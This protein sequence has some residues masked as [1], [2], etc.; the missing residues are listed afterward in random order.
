MN[1]GDGTIDNE[2]WG[3]RRFLYFNNGGSAATS[4]P[5]EAIDHYNYL[6]GFWLDNSPLCYGGTGHTSGGG[7]PSVP[8][9][10]MFPGKPTTDPCGWGQGGTPMPDWSEETEENPPGDRRFVQSAGPFI[11]VPGA[12]NDITVGAVYAK[13]PSGGAW[14]S[15]EPVRKADDKAQILFENCFRVLNGPDAPELKKVKMEKP[16]SAHI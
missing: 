11:L 16:L 15:V 10:F 12:V 5:K 13:A 4:D 1:Y 14:A 3:M 6:T 2:R 9:D 7:D 8:T